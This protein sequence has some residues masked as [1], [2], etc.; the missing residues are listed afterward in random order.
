[1]ATAKNSLRVVVEHWL[2]PDPAKGV[3][4]TEFKNRRS[5]HE[6]YVC[7][8]SLTAAGPI[9]LFFFRHQ[10]GAWRVFPPG[11]ERPAMRPSEVLVSV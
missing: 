4:V 11:R 5:R 3:R 10:D 2:A 8:E 1:M 9:A 6:C 7:V